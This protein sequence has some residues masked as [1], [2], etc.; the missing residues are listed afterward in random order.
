MKRTFLNDGW[1]FAGLTAQTG[2][3]ASLNLPDD[4]ADWAPIPVPGD[5]NDELVKMGQM[6]DPR[7]D[8]QARDC[9]WVTS[10]DWW[11]RRTIAD[12]DFDP[13]T[14]EL[15]FAGIDGHA[16]I[17]LNGQLLG[18]AR[19]A[20]REHRFALGELW[21]AGANE[22]LMRFEAID[23]ALQTP[24]F[25]EL[26]GWRGRRAQMR[27]TQFSFG[28]D[29]ALPLPSIGLCD[30]VWLETDAHRKLTDFSMQPFASGRVDFSFEVSPAVKKAGY[31][32]SIEVSGHGADLRH[33]IERDAHKSYASLQIDN[34]QL[35]WPQGYGAPNLYD[36][37]CVL[38]SES[39]SVDERSGKLGLREV[40]LEERPFTPG[41]GP[42]FSFNVV[43]NGVDIFCKGA[44]VIP[45]ELAPALATDE[46]F[47]WY[48]RRAHEANF[49]MLRLWGGGVYEQRAFYDKC[50]E[51]GLMVWQ[52]FMF[53]ST[54]YP[55]ELLRDEIIAEAQFQLKRL[56]NHASV[57][58][59]CGCN[60]D[61]YSWHYPGTREQS[62]QSDTGPHAEPD[63]TFRV[64][65]AKGDP[66]I[67]SMI[68]RGLTG[69]MGLGAPYLESS[70]QSREDVGNAPMSGN[71]HLSCWKYGLFS[72]GPFG[73]GAPRR[74]REHFDEV[75]SF[76]SEF[77]IQGPSNA[78]TIRQF[79]KPENHWPPNEAWIY[80]IQ[81]GHANLPHYEQT[82]YI[83]GDIFGEI[84]DLDAYVKHGQA[85]H[86]EMMR[87]E[88]EAARRDRPNSGGTMMWM[89]NDCW[90]TANWSIIDYYRRP[91]PS[92]Y[93]A[94]RA[95]APVLPM[96]VARRENIGFYLGNDSPQSGK[97]TLRYGQQTLDGSE[98]WAREMTLDLPRNGTVE[99]DK[100]ARPD[101]QFGAGDYLFIDAAVGGQTLP[102]IVY[103]PDGWRDIVWPTPQITLEI[104]EQSER[105]GRFTS[106]L[107]LQTDAFA[108]F[109]HLV[110]PQDAE[111][112]FEDNF[113]D[114]CAGGSREINVESPGALS[115][116]D[117]KV[118]DWNSVWP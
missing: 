88:F 26:H 93:A 83:A 46:Q 95:C 6:P 72:C 91:K 76:D 94:K 45:F 29:W 57:V 90:P 104:V 111:V 16:E 86:A 35:W 68:L 32:I 81:R 24:R 42:G 67:Y 54:G 3:P 102:R 62:G 14:T 37:R 30:E 115:V 33:T 39:E 9:Y 7:F 89:F 36:Y 15:C 17:W 13:D 18:N 63:P 106:R 59:W 108:R 107:R 31:T 105:A 116:G 23:N 58:L 114:L 51:L 56:R 69:L 66:Q 8:T 109:C 40:R 78:Q 97:V 27:K 61:V 5:V 53:A 96:I 48:L 12:A 100:I 99:F 101:A 85:T 19:N 41:A 79:L 47:D 64:D 1:Q 117:L 77:C 73:Q 70:P 38:H 25:D 75:C 34:P 44:N 74:F 112:W 98:V 118:G 49:N 11:F 82:L 20:F 55:L 21:R 92:Y 65:R 103:F 43:V 28:W 60:E 2:A 80:H 50:D 84:N 52:D 113:F 4:N 71:S 22:L 110:A 10:K 87:A